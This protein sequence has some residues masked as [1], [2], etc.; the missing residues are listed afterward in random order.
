MVGL[1]PLFA[2]EVLE[3]ESLKKAPEF[4]RHLKWLLN[5]RP[6]LARLV[7][8]MAGT[9]SR[10]AP[11][12]FPPARPSNEVPAAPHARLNRIPLRLRSTSN[13]KDP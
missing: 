11:T 10:R 12:A 5:H 6:D 1:I 13:L 4:A 7:S 2:V 9:W 3:P 8:E